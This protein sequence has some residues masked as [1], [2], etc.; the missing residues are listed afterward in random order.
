SRAADDSGGRI[1]P[2]SPRSPHRAPRGYAP[3]PPNPIHLTTRTRRASRV[4]SDRAGERSAG[5]VATTWQER[6]ERLERLDGWRDGCVPASILPVPPVL[7]VPP[8]LN[9]GGRT[10]TVDLALMRRSL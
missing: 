8:D 4:E 2:T 9:A 7:P 5:R 3:A 1:P 10:R 6:R